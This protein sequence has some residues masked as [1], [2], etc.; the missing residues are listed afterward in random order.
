MG[1]FNRRLRVAPVAGL[2]ALPDTVSADRVLAL[3]AATAA[4]MRGLGDLVGVDRGDPTVSLTGPVATS[5][6]AGP[7]AAVG[8]VYAG[9]GNAAMPT[10]QFADVALS[11][12]ALDGYNRT[13]LAR[14]YRS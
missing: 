6:A 7:T 4:S 3:Q 13:L 5:V 14:M 12:P 10:P 11:D 8:A 1:I 2:R 9:E